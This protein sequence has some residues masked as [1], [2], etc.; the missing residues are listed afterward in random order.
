[1]SLR[2][3]VSQVTRI[4]EAAN[5]FSETPLRPLFWM[6]TEDGCLP[7]KIC[8]VGADRGIRQQELCFVQPSGTRIYYQC[9]QAEFQRAVCH[10]ARQLHE[11]CVESMRQNHY[12]RDA[13]LA[14]ERTSKNSN[15]PSIL[16]W[17]WSTE[18]LRLVASIIASMEELTNASLTTENPNK[19]LEHQRV[20]IWG[21]VTH[22][23]TQ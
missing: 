11:V 18:P 10:V 7:Y 23:L 6:R 3:S 17:A 1:M 14:W 9:V 21:L 2:S 13:L 12:S 20:Q 22:A 15:L 4:E 16:Y 19:M 5:R 8:G